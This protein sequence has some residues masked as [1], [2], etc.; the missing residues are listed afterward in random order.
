MKRLAKISNHAYKNSEKNQIL[1]IDKLDHKS[2][3]H[4]ISANTPQKVLHRIDLQEHRGEHGIEDQRER[5]SHLATS[6][7]PIGL[8]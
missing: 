7:G 4:W 2:T 8:W 5:I 3:I 1:F 6:Y